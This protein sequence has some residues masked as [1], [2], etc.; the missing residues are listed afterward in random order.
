MKR[1]AVR[2]GDFVFDEIPIAERSIASSNGKAMQAPSPLNI[3]L[4]DICHFF[5]MSYYSNLSLVVV[6][7]HSERI[8]LDEF[9]QKSVWVKIIVKQGCVKFLKCRFIRK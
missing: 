1:N 9:H 5:F 6:D 2:I 3:L 7:L 4:L 8:T